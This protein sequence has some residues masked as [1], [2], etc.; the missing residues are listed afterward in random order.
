MT[1]I[2]EFIRGSEL[3]I[4]LQF[5]PNGS[6]NSGYK[7]SA[8]GFYPNPHFTRTSYIRNTLSAIG[9]FNYLEVL[10]VSDRKT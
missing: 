3:K 9:C 1:I 10:N 8:F 5:C 4:A 2:N 6:S 7:D